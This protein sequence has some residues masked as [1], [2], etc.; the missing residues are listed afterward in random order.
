[1]LP[2]ESTSNS[3][4]IYDDRK[5]MVMKLAIAGKTKLLLEYMGEFVQV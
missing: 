1:M 3:T 4:K 5:I 2:S